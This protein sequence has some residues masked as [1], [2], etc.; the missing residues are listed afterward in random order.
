MPNL[1]EWDTIGT[2]AGAI[3]TAVAVFLAATLNSRAG[4]NE[5]LKARKLRFEALAALYGTSSELID[6]MIQSTIPARGGVLPEPP[7]IEAF[8]D[9]LA[10]L[11]SISIVD[12]GAGAVS[13]FLSVKRAV[14][15]IKDYRSRWP[16]WP[17]PEVAGWCNA[18]QPS[19]K[20]V[21]AAAK[22]A[23][24]HGYWPKGGGSG[25]WIILKKD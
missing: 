22:V 7:P 20:T 6:E 8:D 13:A 19:L 3:S 10:G 15:I 23:A 14:A 12:L 24:N 16:S 18:V 11:S 25:P 1:Q 5:R 17:A 21:I 9:V 2:W 4:R